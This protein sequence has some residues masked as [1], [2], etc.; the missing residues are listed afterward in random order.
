MT[1]QLDDILAARGDTAA[2]PLARIEAELTALLGRRLAELSF[3]DG[4]VAAFDDVLGRLVRGPGKRLRPV[5]VYWGFRAAGG[6]PAGPAAGA[7]LRVGCAVEFLHACTLICDDLMDGSAT[8][9]GGPAVHVTLAREHARRGWRGDPVAFGQAAALTLGLQAFTW[10]D[11]AICDAGLAPARLAEVL[12]LFTTLR[13]EVIGGQYLDLAQAGRW[14]AGT[15]TGG[16]GQRDALRIARYKSAGYTVAR[17]LQLGAA[18][19]RGGGDGFLAGYGLPLGEAFQLRDDVLGVF[20]DPAVTGKPA[21][22]DIRAGKQTLLLVL[23]RQLAGPAGRRL[24][25]AVAGQPAAT[26]G[27]V[28]QVR[29]MLAG[30]G[31]LD[32]VEQRI[33][34]LAGQ[35]RA[36]LGAAGSLPAD[37]RAALASL[38]GQATER[39]Q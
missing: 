25:D 29:D 4:D 20:G 19:A 26:Q 27:D 28:D 18:V 33:A 2:W 14:P 23:G 8:R 7:A 11:A 5:F 30:C 35:A 9:R 15:R 31:A 24:I 17:P 34:G 22:E 32:A 3:L 37:A 12:R 1:A 36:A 21:G 6:D 39:G 16:A 13:T 10:A 38:A